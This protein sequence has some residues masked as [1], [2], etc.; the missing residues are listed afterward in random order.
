[1]SGLLGEEIRQ[2]LA[3]PAVLPSAVPGG[4]RA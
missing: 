2:E 1:M 4:S 3:A